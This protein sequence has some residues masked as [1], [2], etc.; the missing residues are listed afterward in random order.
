MLPIFSLKTGNLG[1][2]HNLCFI[3]KLSLRGTRLAWKEWASGK[4]MFS[5]AS[6]W[7]GMVRRCD[8]RHESKPRPLQLATFERPFLDPCSLG[9]GRLLTGI[10]QGSIDEMFLQPNHV[11]WQLVG[12]KISPKSGLA[13]RPPNYFTACQKVIYEELGKEVYLKTS[14]GLVYNILRCLILLWTVDSFFA[15]EVYVRVASQAK[16]GSGATV[17]D[18][19]TPESWLDHKMWD[20]QRE[21]ITQNS[22]KSLGICIR[23]FSKTYS[24]HPNASLFTSRIICIHSRIRANGNSQST[25]RSM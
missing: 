15:I 6:L 14:L 23:S 11:W 18:Q 17:L 20:N 24:G 25:Q 22:K 12:E 10:P 19:R 9:R 1:K 3:W 21:G 16:G 5:F 13:I 7:G 2:K 4:A 8:G